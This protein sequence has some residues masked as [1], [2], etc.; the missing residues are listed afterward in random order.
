MDLIRLSFSF[1]V[2]NNFL[3]SGYCVHSR[4]YFNTSKST[5][6]F[7]PFIDILFALHQL[8]INSSSFVSVAC[9][10]TETKD[11]IINREIRMNFH[12]DAIFSRFFVIIVVS[13]TEK[14]W[15]N[16]D[17]LSRYLHEQSQ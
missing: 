10:L 3:R 17:E 9:S 2:L 7:L 5:Q 4:L 12:S 13:T 14:L 8:I 1:G 6:K 15:T 11:K 16:R